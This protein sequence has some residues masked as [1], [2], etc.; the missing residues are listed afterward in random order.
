[1][2]LRNLLLDC[3][4]RSHVLDFRYRVVHLWQRG[5]YL[6][7]VIFS[8]LFAWR[9]NWVGYSCVCVCVC[10]CVFCICFFVCLFIHC[11]LIKAEWQW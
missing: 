3:N 10:V 9:I 6:K 11:S 5:T 4:V 8:A 7:T 2:I 1:L